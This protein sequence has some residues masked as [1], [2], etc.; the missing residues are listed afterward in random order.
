[1][2]T[3]EDFEKEIEQEFLKREHTA[4][5][6]NVQDPTI[7]Q[8]LKSQATMLAM[9]SQQVEVAMMEPFVKARESTVLAD[10]AIKGLIFTAK[11]TAIQITFKNENK[12]QE[13]RV[14]SGRILQD[15]VGRIYH[16]LEPITLA[17]ENDG[18]V[19][20]R[21]INIETQEHTVTRDEPFYSI[22][23]EQ[24]KDGSYINQVRVKVNGD[25]F[26]PTFKFNRVG[27]DDKVYH[28]ES[29]EFKQLKVKFGSRNVI[30]AQLN[31]GDVVVIE[32]FTTYGSIV[33]DNDTAFSFDYISDE[34][35]ND[36]KMKLNKVDEVGVSPVDMAT[37]RELVKY[38]SVYDEN[39]VFLGEFDL[40]LRAK[41]TYLAF[42]NVWNEK[43]EEEIRGSNVDNINTLF[44]SFKLPDES[45]LT[46]SAVE[47]Q[48]VDVIER[49]DDSYKIKFVEPI[50]EKVQCH[51]YATISRMYGANEVKK[52]IKDVLL[53][54]YGKNA[55]IVKQGRIVIK[56]K[57]VAEIL[58]QKV[59]A[60]SDVQG[61]YWIELEDVTSRNPETFTYMDDSSIQITLNYNQY[62]S[63]IW[64]G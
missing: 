18:I 10:A 52:Q 4:A 2:F 51:V 30:G 54:T 7:L 40:L 21:Q 3:K 42:L 62:E 28:I 57:R 24:P 6:W 47:K 63:D 11:P 35:D 61:D 58:R 32:K 14:E 5:L 49:A 26:Y 17:P 13:I 16:T 20:A 9:L 46:T 64:G 12:E 8:A 44:V 41:F 25:L 36:I 59:Q 1:M 38:P 43:K 27:V 37:L 48:I 55:F 34:I 39:A 33:I 50:E 29:D 45:P 31:Q 22:V 23:I 60:I 53:E 56:N 15:S 19:L